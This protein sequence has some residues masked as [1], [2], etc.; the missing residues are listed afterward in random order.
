MAYNSGMFRKLNFT[1][2]FT[3]F[4]LILAIGSRQAYASTR[5]ISLVNT[6]PLLATHSALPSLASESAV[7]TASA[8]ATPS[9]QVQQAIQQKN[10]TDLTA[11]TSK[12]KDKLVEIL[13]QNPIQGLSWYNFLQFGVRRA[14]SNGV[15]ANIIV[16]LLL[17]PVITSVISFSRHVIGLKGFGVYT[18]AVL[19]VAFVSA[20]IINGILLFIIILLAAILMKKLLSR[21]NLQY[22]PRTAMLLW[23]VSLITLIVLI[24]ASFFQLSSLFIINIF[25]LLIIMLLTENFM[26]SQLASSQSEAIQLTAETLVTAVVCSLIISSDVVQKY[27]ILQPELTLIIVA[28]TNILVGRY[29]GLRLL[30]W[31]RFRTV[32]E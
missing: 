8:I 2:G 22:L 4:L 24:G 26:E 10:D 6:A 20:G 14:V 30:E 25:P 28:F 29:S 18:P 13:D 9:A 3:V 23:G 31:I 5:S 12:Q 15:P 1:I 11:T 32:I 7:A 21:L 19:A 17:F 27:V 16:L